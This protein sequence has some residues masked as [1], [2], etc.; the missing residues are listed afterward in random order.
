MSGLGKQDRWVIALVVALLLAAIAG[1][2]LSA[3][4]LSTSHAQAFV[5][6]STTDN[7]TR[8]PAALAG[9]PNATQQP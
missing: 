3:P 9:E 6:D 1:F 7:D 8:S 4:G 5:G 2:A